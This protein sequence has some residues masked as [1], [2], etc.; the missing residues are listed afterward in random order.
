MD[1][2][3]TLE[4]LCGGNFTVG[5]NPTLSAIFFIPLLI[6][7][8]KSSLMLFVKLVDSKA[9]TTFLPVCKKHTQTLKS[10]RFAP[11]FV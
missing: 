11:G 7:L 5:S 10:D 8:T 6:L 1:E 9:F 2:G 4:M 3:A